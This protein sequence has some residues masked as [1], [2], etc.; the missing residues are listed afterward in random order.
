MTIENVKLVVSVIIVAINE[1]FLRKPALFL[2]STVIAILNLVF[3]SG[4]ELAT[5]DFSFRTI[6]DTEISVS[7]RF[8]LRSENQ[9]DREE[10]VGRTEI[11]LKHGIMETAMFELSKPILL[12]PSQTLTLT[13]RSDLTAFVID[14][15][16]LDS[17]NTFSKLAI[18][19][20]TGIIKYQVDVEQDLYL[21]AFQLRAQSTSTEGAL[22]LISVGVTPRSKELV[23]RNGILHTGSGFFFRT[24]ARFDGQSLWP[25]DLE[26]LPWQFPPTVTRELEESELFWVVFMELKNTFAAKDRQLKITFSA[27]NV[28]KTILVTL[29]QG[30]QRIHFHGGDVGFRPT[31]ISLKQVGIDTVFT[32][33]VEVKLEGF[34]SAQRIADLQAVKADLDTILSIGPKYWRRDEFELY[35]WNGVRTAQNKPIIVFDT[36]DYATQSRMFRRLAFYVEKK[37]YRGRI[38][39]DIALHNLR[40]YNAHD[41]AATDLSRFFTIAEEQI[42]ALTSEEII[43]RTVAVKHGVIEPDQTGGWRAID[44]AILSVSQESNPFLRRQLLRHEILHG[45]YFTH[46][47]YQEAVTQLWYSLSTDEQLFW[48]LLLDAVG[49]DTDHLSLVVN[50]FQAYLLQQDDLYINQFIEM[51]EA[52]LQGSHPGHKQTIEKAAGNMLRWIEMHRQ[53]DSVLLDS[54]EVVSS[55]LTFLRVADD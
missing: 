34:S 21:Q 2:C 37:G 22:E 7:S 8:K 36:I 28:S 20:G 26:L 3:L 1:N 24:E 10:G 54:T 29:Y 4:C 32:G 53:M 11:S 39:D 9:L 52:R 19:G 15:Y 13:V 18:V 35:E 44:G 25:V 38:L 43:L 45:L 30:Q 33:L 27:N 41:Y 23:V 47:S 6:D 16:G 40:G 31:G 17:V 49:Y 50:E 14:L 51:W 55:M 46:P 12:S 5:S 48:I 42:F